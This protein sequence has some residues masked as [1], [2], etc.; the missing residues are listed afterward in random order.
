MTRLLTALMIVAMAPSCGGDGGGGSADCVL[1][2]TTVPFP[3][4]S[5]V[6]DGHY[7]IAVC[8]DGQWVDVANCASYTWTSSTGFSYMCH[9]SG[10]DANETTTCDYAFHLCG[11]QSYP[12]CPAGTPPKPQCGTC[13]LGQPGCSI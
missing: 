7:S 8:S 12:T 11:D 13:T 9:C 1:P 2:G 6:C 3:P 5:H 10:G 4:G